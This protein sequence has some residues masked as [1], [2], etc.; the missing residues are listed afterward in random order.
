M[1][2]PDAGVDSDALDQAARRE[3]ADL[4]EIELL[5][6][7]GPA[8]IVYLA[9]D[10]ECDGRLVALKVMPRAPEAGP[11][12]QQEFH[13]AA[14]AA[15]VVDDPH[16]ALMYSAGTS[17]SC[18]WYTSAYIDGPSLAEV[19]RNGPM[20][21]PACLRVVRQVG[22]ALE[23]AHQRHLV[24]AD[25]KPAN[26]LVDASGAARLTDFWVPHVLERLGA[27]GAGV[28]VRRAEYVAP[29][30]RAGQPPGPPAD[31]YALAVLLGE[32]LGG[33]CSASGVTFLGAGV[34]RRISV[35]L[36]RA[37]ATA[38]PDRFATISDFIVALHAPAPVAAAAPGVPGAPSLPAA[39]VSPPESSLPP[40][41]I[42]PAAFDAEADPGKWR[43]RLR[44]AAVALVATV[45]V[46]AAWVAGS[47]WLSRPT[48][49]WSGAPLPLEP[50]DSSNSLNVDSLVAALAPRRTP[51]ALPDPSPAAARR[52]TAPRASPPVRAPVKRAPPPAAR[53]SSPG[54]LFV[55][56]TPWGQVYLDG[57]LIG[58]TPRVGVSVPAGVHQV[59]VERDG[60]Q[61]FE[62]SVTV[63][64]G[65][66]VRVT[67]IVLREV[68][69]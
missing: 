7:R 54:R 36:A 5:H 49:A 16:V 56:A 19:L 17:D 45:V 35:A 52:D 53:P 57:V 38:P 12:V 1:T 64:A 28:V 33:R 2:P 15:A 50:P 40:H 34:P 31:Q 48:V 24:H 3:L 37:L 14:S 23:A 47:A 4:F 67:D 32:C 18:F 51:A 42:D 59:R 66:D 43:R 22:R 68:R 30:E 11:A 69:P 62:R 65:Q 26:V 44:V 8:S 10:R 20:E 29:E 41:L 27:L 25:L 39:R 60:F 13:R 6:R 58:N 46:G 63:V 61:P 21:L 9:R 55:N